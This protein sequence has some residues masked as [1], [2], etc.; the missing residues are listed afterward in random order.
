MQAG[1][2]DER[3]EVRENSELMQRLRRFGQYRYIADVTATTS[4]RRYDQRGMRGV[5]WLWV[6]LWL[7]SL[8]GDLPQRHYEVVR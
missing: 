8:L 3:L 1:G 6:K 4:M 2:F 7:Q 5:V